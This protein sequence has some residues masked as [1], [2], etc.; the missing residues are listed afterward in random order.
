MLLIPVLAV[1][2]LL[3]LIVT[4]AGVALGVN[5]ANCTSDVAIT[6]A[7]AARGTADRQKSIRVDQTVRAHVATIVSVASALPLPERDQQLAARIAIATALQESSLRN[8]TYGDRDSLGLFQQRGAWAPAEQRTDPAT[9]AHMF[10]HGGQAGQPGLMDI[11]G[12]QDMPL[13]QA[14]Q[15]V[16]RSAFPSAYSA[17]QDQASELVADMWPAEGA[18]TG[19]AIQARLSGQDACPAVISDLGQSVALPEGYELPPSTSAP[20]RTAIGWALQQLGTPY[21]YG[22]HCTDPH[23]SDPWG[24]CD[25][26]SLLQ[27][28]YAHAGITIPRTTVGQR[29]SGSAV[30]IDQ[31]RPGDLIFILGDGSGPNDPRHVGMALGDGLL[32]QAP[33]SGDVVKVSDIAGEWAQPLAVRRIA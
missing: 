4:A 13:A 14:A 29:V 7:A 6:N 22:G 1:P 33:K 28:A 8:L 26:S 19:E 17:W 23:G 20:V 21:K 24:R 31:V 3:F 12:W 30:S 5:T 16:Q 18:T 9:A 2:F 27:Q 25:C 11:A 32:V 15:A 10:F